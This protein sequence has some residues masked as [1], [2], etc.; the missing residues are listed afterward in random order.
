[1]ANLRLEHIYKVYPNGTKAV[2]DF[3]MDIEDKEFI[4]FVGPSGCGKSTTL[5]MIAGLED[6]S[7]GELYIDGKVVNDMEPKDRDIAMVFQNYAL[8]PHMTV[9]ENMA[10]GLKL[11]HVP[12]EEIHEKVL[13]AAKVLDLTDYLDRK[14]RAMSGGQRQR[15]AL[16][17]S[18]LRNPKVMLLD[19]PLSNLDAKLRG[20][21][22]TEIAKL[23]DQLQTTFIYVTHDQVE[24]MTL[25][26]RVVVM[27]LGRIM[28]ID[29][30]KNLYDYPDNLFVAG[31]IGTPQMNFFKAN[32]T[33]EGNNVGIK[34]LYSDEQITVPLS[35]LSKVKQ[36]YLDGKTEVIVGVRCEHLSIDE[37]VVAKSKY[38]INAKVSHFEELGSE[39]LIYAD[40]NMNGDGFGETNTRII[41]KSTSTHALKKGEIVKVAV[42]VDKMHLF[43]SVTENNINPRVPQESVVT[44]DVKAGTLTID[45]LKLAVP[46]SIAL[47]DGKYDLTIPTSAI[48]LGEGSQKVSLVETVGKTKVLSFKLKEQVLF[49]TL[50][51]GEEAK[52]AY[53][54]SL[55]FTQVEFVKD[56]ELVKGAI[57]EY[58]R[59]N[60][61][62]INYETAKTYVGNKYD[63]LLKSRVDGIDEKFK[64]LIADLDAKHESDLA[65]VSSSAEVASQNAAKVAEAKAKLNADVKELKAKFKEDTKKINEEYK[66]T[67]KEEAQKVIDTYEDIKNKELADFEAFKKINKDKEAYRKRALELREFKSNFA[68]ERKNEVDKK[69]NACAIDRDTEL[70]SIKGE[71]KRKVRDLKKEYSELVVACDK[72]SN[73]QKFIDKEYKEELSKLNKEY[74]M[75]RTLAGILFFFKTNDLVTLSSDLI[76]N[77]MIQS[78]GIKVF[79]KQ[80]ILEI[81][82]DA[83]KVSEEGFDVE[84]VELLDYETK[85]FLHCLYDG[86]NFKSD[87]YV[88]TELKEVT[89]KNIKL[90]FDVNK[91]HV[92]E[93]SL[94]IKIY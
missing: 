2:S 93:K 89:N 31:F 79:T 86:G 68:L 11:R 22:R 15:V 9:Y 30:P 50:G 44:C 90:A 84:V 69:L 81:P 6:I 47:P 85:R 4:V 48:I 56:G 87:L 37:E 58:D 51:E 25:G 80:Y 5:R 17:R 27:R 71:F 24:A 73:P 66:V 78:L 10:F 43:D 54:L 3:T 12:A 70:S 65:S 26:T 92:T 72:E 59:V 1:M 74:E 62:F 83:Y 63:E 7:A 35:V 55:D 75:E 20:Q 41:I 91:I 34:F 23:H 38:L 28:Q 21:M 40:I 32:L 88:E 45:D 67:S 16:G 52:E 64:K 82:H 18:I 42:N 39:T 13:W 61:M 53:G 77:K 49:A 29:T 33:K 19:E 60:A 14:P 8:Y 46:S 94:D 36:K 57:A 76:S